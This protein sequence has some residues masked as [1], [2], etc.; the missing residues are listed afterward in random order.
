MAADATLGGLLFSL[1][2]LYHQFSIRHHF[3]T[4]QAHYIVATTLVV[5][6]SELSELVVRHRVVLIYDYRRPCRGS[7]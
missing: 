1:R 6:S 4:R 5:D 3:V 2:G 7:E